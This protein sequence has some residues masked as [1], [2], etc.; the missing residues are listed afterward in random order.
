MD[1]TLKPDFFHYSLPIDDNKFLHL[2]ITEY[3]NAIQAAIYDKQPSL[4]SMTLAYSLIDQIEKQSLFGGRDNHYSDALAMFLA[5]ERKKIVYASVNL[6]QDTIINLE[7]I[8][9]LIE[10]YKEQL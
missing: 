7:L 9:N 3:S 5:K 8:R 10:M 6:S 1:S 2:V 4:G